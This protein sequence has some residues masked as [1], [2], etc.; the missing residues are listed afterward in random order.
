VDTEALLIEKEQRRQLEAELEQIKV[1][2]VEV[3]QRMNFLIWTNEFL[4]H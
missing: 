3:R 4:F 2:L 1:E